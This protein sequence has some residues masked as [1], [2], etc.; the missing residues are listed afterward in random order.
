M[1]YEK[2]EE[3]TSDQEAKDIFRSLAGAEEKHKSNIHEAYK[4]ITGKD[5]L[6]T[7]PDDGSLKGIMEGGV[8][9][10]DIIGFLR[11]RDRTVRDSV[12]VS[13]ELETNALD[14]Y[15]KM[16]RE[17][18]DKNSQRVFASL[19]EEEKHHLSMLGELLEGRAG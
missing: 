18:E 14:L 19:V 6:E 9:V 16:L 13:M 7:F 8:Q 15:I 3:M 11:G 1:F 2:A 17:I 10:E 4:M 5:L 12:E